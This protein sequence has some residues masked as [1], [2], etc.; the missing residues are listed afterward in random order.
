[1]EFR[2]VLADYGVKAVPGTVIGF[3]LACNDN[4]RLTETGSRDG[5]FAFNANADSW[6]NT[7]D[8]S[9]CTFVE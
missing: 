3:E 8:F 4:D 1:M 2:F 9:N 7:K 5:V 6:K